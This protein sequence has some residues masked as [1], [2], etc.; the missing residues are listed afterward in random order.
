MAHHDNPFRPGTGQFPAYWS[1]RRTA[2]DAYRAAITSDASG[3]GVEGRMLLVTGPRASGRTSLLTALANLATDCGWTRLHVPGRD[4]DLADLVENRIPDTLDHLSTPDSGAGTGEDFAGPHP[5]LLITVDDL[6][7]FPVSDLTDLTAA[8]TDLVRDLAPLPVVH[9]ASDTDADG[10]D[11]RPAT[12]PHDRPRDDG[13]AGAPVSFLATP[14]AMALQ[15]HQHY[16]ITPFRQRD[17]TA[18]L[19]RT[20]AGSLPFTPDA[21]EWA[22]SASY[23]HPYLLQ[24]IGSLSWDAARTARRER[25]TTEIVDDAIDLAIPMFGARVHQPALAPLT[26]A[27]LEFLHAMCT[28]IEEQGSDAAVPRV[29]TSEIAAELD[30]PVTSVSAVRADLLHRDI[31]YSPAWGK[32]SFRLP[33]LREYLDSPDSPLEVY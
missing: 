26:H 8:L 30:R 6:D 3:I 7:E 19:S 2:L 20:A 25:I 23:G 28:V 16:Q 5:G 21:A 17:A 32:L 11:S 4:G 22:A 31:I 14:G 15:D 1:G 18:L 9:P 27:Q 33:Y 13:H 29:R 12:G 24:L 10:A